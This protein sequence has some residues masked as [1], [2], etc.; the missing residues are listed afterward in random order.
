MASSTAAAAAAVPP[1]FTEIREGLVSMIYDQKE[2]VFY[3]KV[4]VFNRDISLQ[5]I[6]YFAEVRDREK[7]ER[8]EKKQQRYDAQQQHLPAAP[9]TSSKKK[10]APPPM[11]R[12]PMPPTYGVRV[13]DGVLDGL[14]VPETVGVGEADCGVSV[15]E[16]ELLGVGVGEG[17]GAM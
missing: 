2:A 17:A 9:A 5:V 15:A 10:G 4:Q 8:Y 3:N 12:P 11:D 1:G 14:G 6:R 13:L 7:R 16:G